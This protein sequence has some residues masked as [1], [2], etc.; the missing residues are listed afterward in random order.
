MCVGGLPSSRRF[1][2]HEIRDGVRVRGTRPGVVQH[3]RRRARTRHVDCDG[4]VVGRDGDGGC[5]S[6]ALVVLDVHLEGELVGQRPCGAGI[7]EVLDLLDDRDVRVRESFEPADER[8]G[9]RPLQQQGDHAFQELAVGDVAIDLR[10]AI[11]SRVGE[12]EGGEELEQHLRASEV[13][14]AVLVG[15]RE[16]HLN[17]GK[18]L[19]YRLELLDVVRPLDLRDVVAGQRVQ[20]HRHDLVGQRS[21]PVLVDLAFQPE[22]CGVLRRGAVDRGREVSVQAVD[23][24]LF[25]DLGVAHRVASSS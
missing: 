16:E 3:F 5:R 15:V 4:V 22:R 10:E 11:F 12:H 20:E 9:L 6:R 14:V 24:G 21:H 25:R 8:H 1:L 17:L 13:V 19:C 18:L 7:R 2:D 23:E